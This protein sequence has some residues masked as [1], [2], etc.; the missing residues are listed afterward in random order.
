MLAYPKSG[1]RPGTFGGT[2]DW[3]LRPISVMGS[4]TQDLGAFSDMGPWTLNMGSRTLDPDV[5][6]GTQDP[7]ERWNL[8]S[9][10]CFARRLA[11]N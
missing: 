6:P 5:R 2:Q 3:D 11:R 9:R 7:F 1:T 10:Y 8:I 4:G